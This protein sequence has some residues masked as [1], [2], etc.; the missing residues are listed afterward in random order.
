MSSAAFVPTNYFISRLSPE[1]T[2][3]IIICVV[4][5][6]AISML[7]MKNRRL[8]PMN[9][10][11]LL[12]TIKIFMK[13]T[14]APEFFYTNMKKLGLVY[15]L[16]LPEMSPWIVIC[17]SA[18]AQDILANEHEKPTLYQRFNAANNGSNSIVSSLTSDSAWH[19]ARK[20][21]APAFS[22][23]NICYSLPVMYAKIDQFKAIL[24]ERELDGTTFDV[25]PM[26]THMTMDFICAGM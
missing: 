1:I 22:M 15:R 3:S 24:K 9:E 14:G 13:G 2:T 5:A 8:P 11:S 10:E 25:G 12:E 23:A 26:I 19:V 20:G 4:I 6:T 18:L 17:D 16:N 21:L 7:H